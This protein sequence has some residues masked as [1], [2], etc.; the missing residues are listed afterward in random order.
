MAQRKGAFEA[1][2]G[3]T[4]FLDEVGEL[5]LELQSRLLGALER[6]VVQRVGSTEARP[7]DVR[8]V[9][10]TNRDLRR[11]INRGR[12]REDLYFRIAVVTLEMPPLRDRPEDIPLYVQELARDLETTLSIDEPTMKRLMEMQWRGNVRELRNFLERSAALGEPVLDGVVAAP[13]GPESAAAADPLVPF[14]IGKAAVIERFEHSY[15]QQLIE[16]H[17][18]NVS[19]A[20]RAADIDRM[21]LLRLLDKYGLR[22]GRK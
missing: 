6:R 10:A 12:F 15:I 18:G 4:L 14:K 22:P 11:E 16:A 20:A 17:R 3:G 9:A 7:I 5:P 8:V 13:A 2:T 19:R 1:A 21:Y